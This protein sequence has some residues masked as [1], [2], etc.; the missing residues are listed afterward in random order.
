MKDVDFFTPG[1]RLALE[2]ECLLLDTRND[3]AQS[4]WWDSAHE[5]LEQWRQAVR[6]MEA[7]I[8]AVQPEASTTLN[9]AESHARICAKL[10]EEHKDDVLVCVALTDAAAIIRDLMRDRLGASATGDAAG[11]ARGRAEAGRD[12]AADGNERAEWEGAVFTLMGHAAGLYANGQNDMPNWIYELAEKIARQHA[13]EAL[14]ARVREVGIQ[15]R[16]ELAAA[17][18]GEVKP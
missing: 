10:A 15:Q 9:E 1:A 17:L 18:R 14:A 12:A 7:S 8:D 2:L 16:A 6:A 5:A 4:R 3:A 13:D 11:Y